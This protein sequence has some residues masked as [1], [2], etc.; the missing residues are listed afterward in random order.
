M[1]GP[2][3]ATAAPE[4]PAIVRMVGAGV[5]RPNADTELPLDVQC[6][7]L[8][9]WLVTRDRVAADWPARLEA[10]RAK[11]REA[12][13]DVPPE[14]LAAAASSAGSDENNRIDY[15]SALAIR[16]ALAL[17][18][19]GKNLFG[20]LAGQ[21]A[22]W[23][24]IVR[25]YEQGGG[26]LFLAEAAQ[27]LAQATDFTLPSLKRQAARL[28]QAV[29]DAERRGEEQRRQASAAAAAFSRECEAMG[30]DA[31]RVAAAA[32][33]GGGGGLAGARREL[34]RL[35]ARLPAVFD[36]RVVAL[37]VEGS[38]DPAK[39]LWAGAEYYA[40][41]VAHAHSDDKEKEQQAA[42]LPALAARLLP[43]LAEVREGG[44]EPPADGP[45]GEEQ[46][47][48]ED[49]DQANEGGKVIEVDWGAMLAAGTEEAGAGGGEGGG[50]GGDT[51]AATPAAGGGISWDLEVTAAG[52]GGGEARWAIE[53]DGQGEEEEGQQEQQ[54]AAS[55]LGADA[56]N[57]SAN[58]S[59]NNQASAA[60]RRLVR[61]AD[62]RAR[63]AD[64][65]HEL[66]A[67]LVTRLSELQASSSSS[68]SSSL[69]EPAASVDAARC[70]RM[71]AAADSALSALS[72]PS[73]RRLLRL[74]SS[75][76]HLEHQAAALARRAGQEGRLLAAARDSAA[77]QAEAR[78]AL[79]EATPRVSAEAA[80]LR[81]LKART[82]TELGKLLSRR[83]NLQGEINKVLAGA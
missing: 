53:V 1:S 47:D 38:D 27:A 6:A 20:G 18:P 56:D 54:P 42:A 24:K 52:D 15:F 17:R 23:G 44:T 31:A 71:L 34:R 39:D 2:N 65:L 13:K 62:Y 43:T 57:N 75:R 11:A 83:V 45:E 25:A 77:R 81:A 59:D 28:A 49:G 55:S 32:G 3:A 50:G 78:A 82:E 69:P 16:D 12:A 67:F 80:R 10:I 8:A 76:A 5:Q 21:A 19:E 29:A 73:A 72:D 35:A 61:D 36:D 68:S 60:A 70:A 51:A 22:L 64:D 9:E 14:V 40:A 26:A 7:R 79:A 63:L 37:V 41:V 74:A 48:D 58:A 46:E 66:R 4:P 33:G 30:V